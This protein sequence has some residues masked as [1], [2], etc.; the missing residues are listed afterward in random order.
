MSSFNSLLASMGTP[1]QGPGPSVARPVSN[2]AAV[3]VAAP[4][5]STAS[6]PY[7][8]PMPRPV[9]SAAKRKA[10]DIDSGP[11]PKILKPDQNGARPSLHKVQ[12]AP[13]LKQN[14]STPAAPL[15]Y[16]GTAKTTT[17]TTTTATSN[18][19]SKV[20]RPEPR[21]VASS[22]T[23][24]VNGNSK[25]PAKK[26]GFSSVLEKAK[27]VQEAMKAQGASTNTIKH[28]PVEKKG[29]LS[30]K[31]KHRREQEE[32]VRQKQV[33]RSGVKPA[34]LAGRIDRSRSGTPGSGPEAAARR[35]AIAPEPGYRGTMRRVVPEAT[36]Y[37]GTMSKGA[38]AQPRREKPAAGGRPNQKRTL[39]SLGKA[40]YG[41][42]ASW[43]DL[44]DDELEED[45]YGS[46]GSSDMEAGIDDVEV[47]EAA[48]LRA[49]QREDAE[50]KAMEE[51]HARE[52]AERRKKLDALRAKQK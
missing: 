16:R 17:V 23:S 44:D 7:Q 51:A 49:A 45:G 39:D 4:Q 20:A 5:K 48:A 33:G 10:E 21:P 2:N 25:T 42:Y 12:S 27:A 46:E 31:E 28:K 24:A 50:Q 36:A 37:K 26:G 35:K 38:S 9:T 19:P 43:S 32:K 14:A 6:I 52:K 30:T 22:A 40:E 1:K 3:S 47:E 15:P 8:K 34:A 18:A 41:G 11:P 29:V 13:V